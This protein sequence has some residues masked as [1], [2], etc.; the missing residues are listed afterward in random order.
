[1]NI[2]KPVSERAKALYGAADF[3]AEFSVADERDLLDDGHLQ[4]VPR[5]Y[6]VL[7]TNFAAGPEGSTVDL[8][9]P[10]E[11]EGALIWAGHIQRADTKAATPAPVE[12]APDPEPE[13]EPEPEEVPAEDA[14]PAAKYQPDSPSG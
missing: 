7:S 9:L 14:A 2:Y 12:V 10:I 8:A 1:V 5:P 11:I 13:P 3:E 4:L 6:T